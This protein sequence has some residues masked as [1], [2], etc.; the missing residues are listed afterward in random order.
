MGEIKERYV[1]WV[2]I[3]REIII[4]CLDLLAELSIRGI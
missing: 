1:Y 2:L 4:V 3:E